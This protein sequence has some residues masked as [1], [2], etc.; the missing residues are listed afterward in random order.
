M[1]TTAL[2]P[3]DEPLDPEREQKL[4]RLHTQLSAAML[5]LGLATAAR[6]ATEEF[7]RVAKLEAAGVGRFQL[8]TDLDNERKSVSTSVWFIDDA[9]EALAIVADI[10]AAMPSGQPN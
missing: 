7:R 8:R 5:D 6:D 4:I 10:R 2:P 1:E 9:G 3:F